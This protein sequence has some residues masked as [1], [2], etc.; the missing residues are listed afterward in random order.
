M[1]I[2][3][4]AIG[5]YRREHWNALR[6]LFTDTSVLP[7][8]YDAWYTLA[9]QLEQRVKAQGL[10]VERV[11]I[12]PEPF[13]TWCAERGIAPDAQARTRFGNETVAKKYGAH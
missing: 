6:R 3:V 7:A 8:T 5:W 4:M 2:R 13:R 10:A 11:F 12:E 9:E 1:Q